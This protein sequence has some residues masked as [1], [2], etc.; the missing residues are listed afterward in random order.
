[1]FMTEK[2]QPIDL[3]VLF[4]YILYLTLIFSRLTQYYGYELD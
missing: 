1:M 4:L 2:G 3:V